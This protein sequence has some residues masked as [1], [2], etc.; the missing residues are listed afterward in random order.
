MQ[1][2]Q[3]GREQPKCHVKESCQH[4]ETSAGGRV[5]AGPA[6]QEHPLCW[7]TL[8]TKP[9]GA[10][11]PASQPHTPAKLSARSRCMQMGKE[12]WQ[13]GLTS[14]SLNPGST[15]RCFL[16]YCVA[17]LPPP[18]NAWAPSLEPCVDSCP[19]V[20]ADALSH[21]ASLNVALCLMPELFFVPREAATCQLLHF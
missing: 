18:G 8:G 2:P 16:L 1:H 5:G 15:L 17:L 20:Q 10:I 13:K 9:W 7:V 14:P 4:P 19:S 21:S 3:Q 12:K 6:P 11:S